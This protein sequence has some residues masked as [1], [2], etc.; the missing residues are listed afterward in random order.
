MSFQ[1]RMA[2]FIRLFLFTVNPRSRVTAASLPLPRDQRGTRASVVPE[3]DPDQMSVFKPLKTQGARDR[4]ATILSGNCSRTT[5]WAISPS[6]ASRL[7]FRRQLTGFSGVLCPR[8]KHIE[9]LPN[10]AARLNPLQR[11]SS[12]QPAPRPGKP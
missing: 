5:P 8:R 2:E 12:G 9:L 10:V 4:P 11:C 6:S 7:A 1:S 3:I